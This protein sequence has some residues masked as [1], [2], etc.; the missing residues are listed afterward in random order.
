MAVLLNFVDFIK[1]AFMNKL[2]TLT[3]IILL[4]SWVS[5]SNLYAQNNLDVTYSGID[6]VP[7]FLNVCGDPD[8]VIVT[9]QT[10][11][12]SSEIRSNIQAELNLFKGIEF[13]SLDAAN[14]SNGVQIL[15]DS[16][17][18]KP[19]FS[20]PDLSPSATNEVNIA[21]SIVAKCGIVDTL[22]NNNGALVF[23]TWNLSYDLGTEAQLDEVS[24]IEYRNALA[25]SFFTMEIEPNMD[26]LKVGDCFDRNVLISN[27]AL[28]GFV[29]QV[30]YQNIQGNGIYIESISA[31]GSLIPITKS[32]GM[33][34]DTIL[35]STINGTLFESNT[36]G[37]NTGNT[38]SFFDPDETLTITERVCIV[39]CDD[40]RSSL[41]TTTWGCDEEACSESFVDDFIQLGEGNA[42][43]I[44]NESQLIPSETVGYCQQGSTSI[45]FSNDGFELDEGFGTMLDVVVGIGMGS[46]FQLSDGGYNANE[47][48]IAGMSMPLNAALIDLGDSDIFLTDVDGVGGLTDAD[49]DGY[50]DDL[51]IGESI[52]VTLVYDF[53]CSTADSTEE[54]C[55]NDKSTFF[56]ASIDYTTLGCKETV[57][58]F[59]NA[60]LR[61]SNNNSELENFSTPDAFADGEVFY[62]TH[63]ESRSIR[64]FERN[65][66]GDDL[67]IATIELPTG[68]NAAFGEIT[69]IKNESSTPMT[70]IDNA[71]D[72][73][74]WTVTFDTS[75]EDFING[76]Y[77]LE[78]GL[79]ADCDAEIGTLD[80][81]FT[82]EFYCPTCDCKHLWYCAD[83]PGPFIHKEVPPCPD[84]PNLICQQGLKTTS[85]EV[86]R[87]TF[88]FTDNSY[89]IPFNENNA[90]KKVAVSCDSVEMLITTEVGESPIVDTFGFVINYSNIDGTDS[91]DEIFLFGEGEL[92][93][94]KGG[95][96]FNC[97]VT[98]QNLAV[99]NDL[100]FKTV[101]FQFTDCLSTL[102]ITLDPGDQVN[103][104]G[105]FA[106]NPE[107]PYVVQFKK[108]P[109]F[110]AFGYS[111]EEGIEAA[112][113]SFGDIFTVAQTNT[114][115]SFPN[116]NNFP[117]G[118]EETFL[119]YRI[120]SVFNGFDEQYGEEQY[121]SIK[122]D[123]IAF[124]FDPN[125]LI[126]F[127]VFE[128]EVSI[129]GH[130]IHG[131]DYFPVT[132][133]EEFTNG[134]YIAY[135]DTLNIVP[136]LNQVRSYSF[137]FRVR[138]VPNCQSTLSS[139]EGTNVY[140]FDP[141]VYY[142]NRYY[143]NFIGDDSCVEFRE[144]NVQNDIQYT[145]PPEFS[146]NPITNPDLLLSTDTAVWTVQL[147]NTSF[148]ADAGLT[149]FAV[150]NLA[151]NIEVVGFED[152]S[153][154]DSVQVLDFE[155]YGSEGNNY[156]AFAN[157][158]TRANGLNTV[159]QICNT[160]RI[161]AIP[162]QCG[163]LDLNVSTGWNC[164]PYSETDWTP[165]NYPPCTDLNI[166]LSIT[167]L[168]PFLE[169]NLVDQP[170]ESVDLCE[171][172]ELTVLV[173]NEDV[174][175]AYDIKT[176]IYVP[177]EGATLVPGSVEFAYPSGAEFVPAGD[178]TYVSSSP[179][180]D[181][182]EFDD[183]SLLNTYLDQN[184]LQG[185]SPANP[186]DSNEFR[187]RYE[188]ITDCDFIGNSLSYYGFQGL[189]VC[190]DSSNLE[191]GESLPI[192]I[193]GSAANEGKLYDIALSSS[194]QLVSE[195]NTTLEIGI[196]NLTDI[197][198][199]STEDF[200][201][202][203]LPMGVIYVPNSTA[204]I[205]PASWLL[206][207]PEI[208]MNNGVN[209]LIWNMPD[210]LVQGSVAQLSFEVASPVFDCSET[211]VDAQL[212]TIGATTFNCVTQ[213]DDCTSGEITS[214]NGADLVSVPISAGLFTIDI[215]SATSICSG[216]NEEVVTVNGLIQVGSQAIPMGTFDID[217]FVDENGNGTLDA[218]EQQLDDYQ[219]EGPIDANT[220]IPFSHE[221]TVASTQ[222]C[223]I[224]FNVDSSD[225]LD[226]E[227]GQFEFI[228]D[229]P[230]LQNSG[231]NLVACNSDSS[232]EA[233][234]GDA[235]C[236]NSDFSYSWTA[237]PASANVFISN[238]S[239]LQPTISFDPSL[240]TSSELLFVLETARLNC[241]FSRDTV[242]VTLSDATNPIVL[243]VDTNLSIC[244]NDDVLISASG[245][246]NYTWINSVTQEVLSTEA[247]L[248]LNTTE[249]IN[250]E[251][252][253]STAGSCDS[254]EV[255]NVT[256]DTSTNCDDPCISPEVDY[257]VTIPSTC[258]NAAGE[259][260]IFID[261]P[262]NYT[263]TWTP[264]L[265]VGDSNSRTEL[266][267]G[268]Y[269]INIS[270][271]GNE[272]CFTETFVLITNTDGAVASATTQPSTCN[273]ADGSVILTPD[274]YDYVW[275]DGNTDAERSDLRSGVYFVTFT[276][277]TNP[278]CENVVEVV[279]DED[280]PLEA[281]ATISNNPSCDGADGAASISV[282]GGSGDYEYIWEDGV[283][284]SERT[285]LAHGIHRV[286]ITDLS[287][288][289]CAL[290]F[291]FVLAADV[292]MATVV[293]TEVNDVSCPG[294][295]DGSASIEVTYAD[296]FVGVADTILTNSFENFTNG[297]LSAGT[298]CYL[299]ENEDGCTAGGDC[300]TIEEPDSLYISFEVTPACNDAGTVSSIVYGGTS[301]YTFDWAD[302]TEGEDTNDR[303]GLVAGNYQVI[304]QDSNACETDSL[305]I[306]IPECNEI[307]ACGILSNSD[308]LS[309]ALMNCEGSSDICL[310]ISTTDLE[311]YDLSINGVLLT[312]TPIPCDSIS[313]V[314]YDFQMLAGQGAQGPY[315][316]TS[317]MVNDS[318]YT[319]SFENLMDLVD[320]MNTNDPN[321]NWM[322]G[323]NN[324]LITGGDSDNLYGDL[325][326]NVTLFNVDA[327][328]EPDTVTAFL[329]S[330]ITL[331]TGFYELVLSNPNMACIDTMYINI[332]CGM[333]VN[334]DYFNGQ[335]SA[336][337]F[338]ASCETGL[339]E[340]C[341]ESISPEERAGYQIFVDS[342]PYDGL[343]G[344]CLNDTLRAYD[345][346]GIDAI[347]PT[348]NLGTWEVNDTMYT[349]ETF[350][351]VDELV[352]FMN[353]VDTTSNW[354]NVPSEFKIEG[355]NYDLND[356]GDIRII[357]PNT[358]EEF[359]IAEAIRI[360][361]AAIYIELT[362]GE[363]EVVIIDTLTS[364]P[365]T[366][367]VDVIDNPD[368]NCNTITDIIVPTDTVKY[369]I[370]PNGLD[371]QGDTL[372]ITNVCEENLSGAVDFILDS[373][374][375]SY[376]G[377]A[378]GQ[379]TACIEICDE[380][381]ICDTLFFDITVVSDPSFIVD[382]IFV[383]QTD[384]F[385][386]DT[387][388]FLGSNFTIED[389]CPEGQDGNVDF[390]IDPTTYCIE[391]TGL[392]IGQDSACIQLC[393]DLGFC[394][395]I[396]FDIFVSDFSDQPIANDDVD[397]TIINTPLIIDIKQNDTL[398]GL[399]DTVYISE[400]PLYGEVTINLDCSATYNPDE[401]ICDIEDQFTYV[402]CNENGC[403]SA[404][405][406]I[407]IDCQGE[408]IIYTAVS[409]N[410]DGSNDTFFIAGIE[411][412]PDSRLI[413]FN[414]WGNE[415]LNRIGYEN[416][417]NGTWDN[418]KVLPDGTYFYLLQLN[419]GTSRT[420]KGYLELY[421]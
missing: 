64:E 7:T 420:F 245:A 227:C 78:I 353:S 345:Y 328:I 404:S 42:N 221:F 387:T 351:S 65:C 230:V 333:D 171:P 402:I 396:Y 249:A 405:V 85:F 137:S 276:D 295:N 145:E 250:I 237:I 160:I 46:G 246:E 83:L 192:S 187:I 421:R 347:S 156:F 114:L 135:F 203:T 76:N 71:V 185:F 177:L 55:F 281:D 157:G 401:G 81:P 40:D 412:Y 256:I 312:E 218:G 348:F 368:L 261:E 289:G 219:I 133:F 144:E 175:Y 247:T 359:T 59:D 134:Q 202:F 138:A 22:E 305:D 19:V 362:L 253:G 380:L 154:P 148:E 367:Y 32:L 392:E 68:I 23:D 356:Y 288:T 173:R 397:T 360:D 231:E 130:P 116:S 415:V 104:R 255:I 352:A 62:I 403:D 48:I 123:S 163:S 122:V 141:T 306:S 275:E 264:D 373:L 326:I 375:I 47:I 41:H 271:I 67:L 286:T 338:V 297:N 166:P 355:G 322:L 29:D 206:G 366:I 244:A 14:T 301:P 241:G 357:D 307:P 151:G 300:F 205:S 8:D 84:D 329:G 254:K 331:D 267:L 198:S 158:V 70:I 105:D 342:L 339:G 159:D 117:E 210:G 129:P 251:V 242:V 285:D 97:P 172:V 259:A 167:T 323:N 168:D 24:T 332:S 128:P 376:A 82:F 155:Q 304:V 88:G 51:P 298:Y 77:E 282:T 214:T 72:G 319:G 274:D 31:N 358:L 346:V 188:I 278:D 49:G 414:R 239:I 382:T 99:E 235:N 224:L 283:T 215:Q 15:D 370:N 96:T 164:L 324:L 389:F 69:L 146:F 208:R 363:H 337:V 313:S 320:I 391:Y 86:N 302:L 184:G 287:E 308:T 61:I 165:E 143:A 89:T 54:S 349:G 354:V 44:I 118:C 293:L 383:N 161:K 38:D 406:F 284:G 111:I 100:G 1:N 127:D 225:L 35:E 126:G 294:A 25:I 377:V 132:S 153:S 52:D 39:S 139:S 407:Y 10:S 136:S 131:N 257:I 91:A 108:V 384:T 317:W 13:A 252:T 379:D 262:L 226:S 16:D 66:G 90:N 272:T 36:S 303:T 393:D 87:S 417:W 212:V 233:V 182:Y 238:P 229:T 45:N 199:S 178:P 196:T 113:E 386:L 92:E 341:I 416:D 109:N 269:T 170:T 209:T 106:V 119:D 385:C 6:G 9:I 193:T 181:L 125:V 73:S 195:M 325:N 2:F 280:N 37:Q 74:T 413:V 162:I 372:T 311:E 258:G 400:E 200:I 201:S 103:F 142:Q 176:Q 344:G 43:A 152:I 291:L 34:G 296:D 169:A 28:D 98:T 147:C 378:L 277:P 58:K 388:I 350:N 75:T 3:K 419:D 174:G 309:I 112:C 381:G 213:N 94:I 5:L 364:C 26:A 340:F 395:T 316:L 217:Y 408:I 371:V 260:T 327:T 314:A 56:S 418:N 390:F 409:P 394:D 263:F 374:C 30:S 27:S 207:E 20:I 236:E 101:R 216:V 234:L 310:P 232:F 191:I 95:S 399:I 80:I 220:A 369:I 60:Y 53:D 365:D 411:F 204:V 57:N 190:Q 110:R 120:I 222:V 21:F 4:F 12:F 334:C 243:D 290:P 93:I 248:T 223:S 124:E 330:A 121:P 33:D 318:T 315:D 240:V 17:P 270:E 228:L 299:I 279:I 336:T 115:F 292:P 18:T 150:D 211:G 107:G 361:P 343:V 273:A 180:G 335:D 140:N 183:F 410:G 11:G 398:L 149:W 179:R 50:F 268:G 265:G 197:A 321:G 102:G 194:S 266:P 186:T 63:F 189:K 79:S